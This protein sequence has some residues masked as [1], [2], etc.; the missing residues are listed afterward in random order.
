[1][2]RFGAF[3]IGGVIGGLLGG[4]V[5]AGWGVV[6]VITEASEAVPSTPKY[7]VEASDCEQAIPDE[8]LTG[9]GLDPESASPN[10]NGNSCDFTPNEGGTVNI[11]QMDWGYTGKPDPH[12]RM[13][14]TRDAAEDCSDPTLGGRVDY[15]PEWLGMPDDAFSC[16]AVAEDSRVGRAITVT[17]VGRSTTDVLTIEITQDAGQAASHADWQQPVAQLANAAREAL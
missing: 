13:A 15:H 5:L 8:T 12:D 11:S 3:V 6:W 10:A 2:N 16:V 9:L 17:V 7:D 14:A 1:M 4:M